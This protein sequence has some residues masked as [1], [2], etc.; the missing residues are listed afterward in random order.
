MEFRVGLKLGLVE[1]KTL[2]QNYIKWVFFNCQT[3]A[4]PSL[5][6]CFV[7]KYF[8]HLIHLW[9]L[10]M[11]FNSVSRLIL[12]YQASPVHGLWHLQ[13]RIDMDFDFRKKKHLWNVRFQLL[14]IR[15]CSRYQRTTWILTFN[16]RLGFTKEKGVCRDGCRRCVR[17]LFLLWTVRFPLFHLKVFSPI[18]QH[19]LIYNF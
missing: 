9:S 12:W 8:F 16:C 5:F 1:E 13:I 15:D 18:K 14:L 19:S 17:V 11:E 10:T 4:R 3:Q 2:S 6:G 7:F